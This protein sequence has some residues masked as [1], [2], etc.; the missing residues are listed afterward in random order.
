MALENNLWCEDLKQQLDESV[1]QIQ[2]IDLNDDCVENIME[3]LK[4]RDLLNASD[5]CKKFKAIAEIV[6]RRKYSKESVCFNLYGQQNL[7]RFDNNFIG[8]YALDF[9]LP[10]FRCF[11][12]LITRLT[13]DYTYAFPKVAQINKY[14]KKYCTESLGEFTFIAIRGCYF[15][16]VFKPFLKVKIV[17]FTNCSLTTKLKQVN[18]WFP[19]MSEMILFSTELT[20]P[21]QFPHLT[22]FTFAVKLGQIYFGQEDIAKMIL[23]NPQLQSLNINAH[24][25]NVR[26]FQHIGRNRLALNDL[27]LSVSLKDL[28]ELDNF[29]FNFRTVKMFKL[30]FY[31]QH[32]LPKIPFSFRKLEEFSLELDCMLNNQSIDFIVKH[33]TIRKLNINGL[34]EWSI[35][36]IAKALPI[37]TDM[38]L[39]NSGISALDVIEFIDECKSVKSFEFILGN[40]FEENRS[41]LKTFLDKEWE[42]TFMG[43]PMHT[44]NPS[45]KIDR[46]QP[47]QE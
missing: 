26:K 30:R 24:R 14:I 10:F 22:K 2:I 33:P 21:M 7:A 8:I 28:N 3:N 6:F 41:T 15:D 46:I 42:I 43:Y 27:N 18:E 1:E 45:V 36:R 32:P 12:H 37:L 9:A 40:D 11:G 44:N 20:E 29:V 17:K 35:M 19:N 13:L 31:G 4:I 25:L 5:T 39:T 34:G 23:L 47:A 16:N 38:K